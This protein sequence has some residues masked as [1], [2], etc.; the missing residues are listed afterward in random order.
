MAGK[1]H[2]AVVEQFGK[3]LVQQAWDIPSPGPGQILVKTEAL[4][5]EPLVVKQACMLSQA[6]SNLM[7]ASSGY[8]S[9]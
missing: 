8:A 7:R 4:N 5:C 2:V 1:M 9:D 3:V 6:A